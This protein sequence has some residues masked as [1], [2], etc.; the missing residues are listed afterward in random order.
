RGRGP[1]AGAQCR[2]P[3][4]L[5]RK[6]AVL[7]REQGRRDPRQRGGRAQDYGR[8]DW[9]VK[10]WC[11]GD[12]GP[13]GMSLLAEGTKAHSLVLSEKRSRSVLTAGQRDAALLGAD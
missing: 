13:E 11:N 3:D 12:F 1:P 4:L 9:P 2:G 6:G 5:R 10:I 7:Q 8:P